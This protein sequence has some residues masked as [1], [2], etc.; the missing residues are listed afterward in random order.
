MSCIRDILLTGSLPGFSSDY[1]LPHPSLPDL[2]SA[3]G[4][5]SEP[6]RKP[7]AGSVPSKEKPEAVID[8]TSLL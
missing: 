1:P 5:E 7:F 6:F 2:Q 4:V 3:S 8:V